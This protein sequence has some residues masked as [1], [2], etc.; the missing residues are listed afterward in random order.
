MNQN[1]ELP[2]WVRAQKYKDMTGHTVNT[3]KKLR[4]HDRVRKGT[5]WKKDLLN[6]IVYNHAAIDRL[7]DLI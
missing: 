2:K 7:T 4:M 1:A 5:H 6:G 3:L